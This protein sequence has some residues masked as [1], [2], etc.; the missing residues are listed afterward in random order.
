MAVE[1]TR[2][3]RARTREL[4]PTA[5]R[6]LA[7][8]SALSLYLIVISG[9]LVRLTSSGL[10]CE[11]WPG[12]Q[13]GSFF[14]A[15]SHHAFVEFGNRVFS[16]VPIALSL[17]LW[18]GAW[19][20]ATLPR[21]VTWVAG[22]TFLGT[23]GQAP[24]GMVTIYSDLHPLLVLSH[25]VLALVVLAGAVVVAVEAL[26]H[27]RGWARPALPRWVRPASL[28]LAASCGV[29]VVTGTLSTAAGPHSGGA[30]IRRFGNLVDAVYVHVRATAV[31]G[32]LLAALLAWVW[33][34][35]AAVPGIVRVGATLLV[36]L[37][38]QMA[39]GE[40]QW[41]SALPWGVVLVHVGLAAAIW[42][43]TVLLATVLWRTPAPLART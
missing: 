9:G 20:T 12:C 3:A 31:F 13:A 42:G 7:Y 22:L 19:R 14:P 39:V 43:L 11:S 18:I 16:L 2:V 32:V 10:G 34:S 37:L 17:A 27:E 6:R 35:R 26:G 8:A 29:L 1:S 36:V 33:R 15:D 23:I 24:L 40:I 21:W 41:R 28:V 4:S 38:A 5:F 30:D 25:F